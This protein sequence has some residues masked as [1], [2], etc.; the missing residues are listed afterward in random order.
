MTRFW[1]TLS[2]AVDFVL[3]S[4]EVMQGG[5]LFVPK[6]PT[7]KIVDLAKTIAPEAKCRIVG[8]RPGEKLHECL[9]TLDEG[10]LTY[11]L[12]DRYIVTS[13]SLGNAEEVIK[14]HKGAK[15][16]KEGFEYHSHTNDDYLTEARM[17]KLLK[18]VEAEK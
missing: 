13:A 1:I 5:E 2:Q 10:R 16:M 8:I 7:M 18:E 6:I 12:K 9:I 15:K 3:S 11:E 17:T 4:L 14:K